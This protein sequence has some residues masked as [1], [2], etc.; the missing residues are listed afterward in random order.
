MNL[1]ILDSFLREYLKT[2][3]K[4]AEI[5][6]G[7]SLSGPAVEFLEKI[8]N[9]YSYDLE[10]T[11]NRIDMA[12]VIG[13]AREANAALRQR[14][15]NSELKL[16]LIL[17]PKSIIKPP[18]PLVVKDPQ[19]LSRRIMALV[20]ADLEVATSPEF[21]RTRLKVAGIRALNNLIDI[22][23]Y[24]MLEMGHP[25]HIFDYDKIKTNFLLFRYA[26]KNEEIIT[27]DGLK[28]KL[29]ST[30]V[31]ID[32]G[33]G[34]IIDLPGI[35]GARNSMVDEQTKRAV[36]F[37]EMND[38]VQIRRTS[39]THGINTLAAKYNEN[40]PDKQTAE[41]AF[42]RGVELLQKYASAKPSSKL[43]NLDR[44]K[45]KEKAIKL[46]LS[47]LEN[48][49]GQKIDPKKVISILLNLGFVL[50]KKDTKAFTFTVPLS[51]Y[52]DI[53]LPEDLIEEVARI[54]GFAN[55]GQELPPFCYYKD[56]YLLNLETRFTLEKWLRSFLASR[57]FFE[58]L[59]YSMVSAQYNDLFLS[60]KQSSLKMNNP[61]SNEL[62][63][64]RQTL[65]P[66]LIKSYTLN[67]VN[68][69]VSLFE[70]GPVY[71]P[72]KANLPQ[73]KPRLGLLSTD[74]YFHVKGEIEALLNYGYCLPL[75]TTKP[76]TGK[77]YFDTYQAVTLYLDNVYFGEVGL[78]AAKIGA[79]LDLKQPLVIAELDLAILAQYLKVLEPIV[80][81]QNQALLIEDLTYQFDKKHY[82]SQIIMA[83]KHR[84]KR[85]KKVEFVT[86]YQNCY[87]LRRYTTAKNSQSIL[88]EI[89]D[90]LETKF[91]LKIKRTK[92]DNNKS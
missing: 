67:S 8:G 25:A 46:P 34:R 9:D 18:F 85:L 76:G 61:L 74:P 50:Q 87:T 92:V 43:I 17:K 13:I 29:N 63:Y 91:N 33:T 32:D 35:M 42:F 55:L 86:R 57:G 20:V 12:S 82:Y 81:K 23:N 30:D 22:T 21:I 47:I 37:V 48:Y 31:V 2:T 19:H 45:L 60:S 44:I 28:Y 62:V 10:I 88:N 64:F 72:E 27:L 80:A 36:L 68:K 11:T 78:L 49:L 4:P 69:N 53:N 26:K 70:I 66:T 77:S 84:F 75:L 51:R 24:I 65:L 14:G 56:E 83:L 41:R 52:K 15:F 5:A 89:I 58:V 73:E 3:A 7:L 79:V 71:L 59:N 39:M 1:K 54:Y 16:P 6:E 40:G 38:P 90:F